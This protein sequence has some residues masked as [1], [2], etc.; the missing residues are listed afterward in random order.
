LGRSF[1]FLFKRH[2][3]FFE[4]ENERKLNKLP[5]GENYRPFNE[6]K[7]LKDILYDSDHKQIPI[8]NF[9]ARKF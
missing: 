9:Q 5:Y 1:Y 7:E 2:E 3:T 4:T 6:M 8:D